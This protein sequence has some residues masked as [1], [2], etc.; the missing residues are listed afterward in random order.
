MRCF[1]TLFILA[2]CVNLRGQ[3]PENPDSIKSQNVV[4]NEGAGYLAL[5]HGITLSVNSNWHTPQ[6]Y[7]KISTTPLL[8]SAMQLDSGVVVEQV[9]S[10]FST[11]RSDGNPVAG[12]LYC[13]RHPYD[14]QHDD[15][16]FNWSP[17]LAYDGTPAAIGRREHQGKLRGGDLCRFVEDSKFFQQAFKEDRWL[18]IRVFRNAWIK[19]TDEA[20]SLDELNSILKKQH[21]ESK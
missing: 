3:T 19:F 11:T 13:Y 6:R 10:H 2:I 16:V 18:C 4:A 8:F 17:D 1:V 5:A 12:L 15:W 20:P 9:I 7:G 14:L 21:R